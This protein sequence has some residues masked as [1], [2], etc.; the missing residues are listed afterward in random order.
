MIT[1]FSKRSGKLAAAPK[2][3]LTKR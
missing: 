1:F 3:I 2:Y